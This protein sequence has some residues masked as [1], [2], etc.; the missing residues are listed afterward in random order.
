MGRGKL[1]QRLRRAIEDAQHIN[2]DVN[3]YTYEVAAVVSAEGVLTLIYN[4]TERV[5]VV[6]R[7]EGCC[8]GKRHYRK[9][10]P[11][12]L[13]RKGALVCR[14]CHVC[15][16]RPMPSGVKLPHKTEQQFMLVVWALGIDEQFCFQATPDFW[17]HP[18][19]FYNHVQRY[20]IQIDGACHWCDMYVQSCEQVLAADFAQAQRAVEMAGTVVRV[21]ERDVYCHAAVAATLAAAQ[22]FAG[23]VLSPSYTHQWVP[24]Q[25]KKVPYIDAVMCATSGLAHTTL[26]DGIVRIHKM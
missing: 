21:H 9:S 14:F 3:L 19:D 12:A 13:N 7:C 10:T 26:A 1:D 22:G 23:V 4:C 11:K 18:M 15:T 8:A 17:P 24:Y 25:G 2:R 5:K 16:Q 6:A 20:Y